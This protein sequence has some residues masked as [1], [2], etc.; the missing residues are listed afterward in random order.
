M[1]II[2]QFQGRLRL[3]VRDALLASTLRLG[4]NARVRS[5]PTPAPK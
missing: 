1:A 5:G 4:G 3:A 2:E